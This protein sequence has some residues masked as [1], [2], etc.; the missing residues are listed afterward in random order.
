MPGRLQARGQTKGGTWPSRPQG[1]TGSSSLAAGTMTAPDESLPQEVRSSKRN[2][3]GPKNT[4]KI[5]TWNVRTMF[6][7]SK[8]AQ[9]YAP[10]NDAEDDIKDEWYEQV[11]REISKT[12]QHDMLIIM[13]DL[14]AKVGSDNSGREDAMGR[15]GCGSINDNGERLVDLCLSNRLVIGGTIFPHKTIHK[16]TWNSP[17]GHT[18][19]QIDHVMV[20]KKWQRSVLDV[21]AYRGA[22][23]GSD[24]HLVVTKVRLKLRASP[25]T[26][27]RCKVFDTSKLRKPEIRRE[28]A[29]ELRNRFKALENL[30][31][32]EEPNVVET[33]WD[34]I[35]KVYSE[36][37]KKVLGHRKRKDKEWLTQET[38]RKIEE[39]KVA[40]QK[41]LT[42]KTQQAKEAYRNKD[43]QVKRSA[44]RDKRAFVEDLAT[45]AEQAATR[46]ELSTVYR[47]TKK[48]CNQ[49]SASSV[50]I[51]DKQ[52]KLL[53]S[54]R[55]QT[56]RWAQ[57][58]EEVLSESPWVRE[59]KA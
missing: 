34:T 21:R 50:P 11:Q 10:T 43:K 33:S 2:L 49:S 19:N 8:T 18:I 53:T 25:P 7:L 23:V 15:H 20:N 51:K 22:D 39:R 58:F 17:D 1:L 31:D 24:H 4:I 28:F 44:R 41:L 57:H 26:K 52:G 45:E 38:W 56:A 35:T 29:L 13:G 40:K 54:E 5:G 37:A 32:E 14:N 12:P 16:L 6:E 30:V 9:C 36:T 42:S 48:L 27:Q 55:E 59:E 3:L 47:I 46:G